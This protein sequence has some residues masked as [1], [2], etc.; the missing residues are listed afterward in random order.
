MRQL[1]ETLD[2]SN[3]IL[4]IDV[5]VMSIA[6]ARTTRAQH[7]GLVCN[8]ARQSRREPTKH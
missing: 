2:E 5:V 6:V 1:L 4:A 8:G 3:R 7:F